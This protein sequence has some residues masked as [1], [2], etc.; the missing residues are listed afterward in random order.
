MSRWSGILRAVAPIAA[1]A[2]PGAGP[3]VAAGLKIATAPRVPAQQPSFGAG[4]LSLPIAPG[5]IIRPAAA[6]GVVP[7]MMGA[8]GGWLIGARGIVTSAAGKILGVMRGGRLFR[9]K[10]VFALAKSV[11]IDT[12]AVILGVTTVEVAQMIFAHQETLGRRRARGI[13]GRDVKITR[14]TIGRIRGIEKS[15]S[16]SGICAPRG[17]GRARTATGTFVRQG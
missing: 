5:G 15:L 12:A 10:K 9:N 2:I 8:M 13:S 11:G 3:F 16:E 1:L 17:R 6:A 14:R 7:R 4:S